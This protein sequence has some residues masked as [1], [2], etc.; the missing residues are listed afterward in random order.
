MEIKMQCGCGAHFRITGNDTN[1]LD[2]AKQWR[3]QHEGCPKL[4]FDYK[5]AI[6]LAARKP[7]EP[8]V[9]EVQA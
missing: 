9:G 1:V 2:Q 6:A 4:R 3:T 7:T 8:M 5:T